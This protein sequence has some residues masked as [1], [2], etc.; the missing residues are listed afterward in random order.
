MSEDD[1]E[2]VARAIWASVGPR[3]ENEWGKVADHTKEQWRGMARAAIA[4]IN[5][6]K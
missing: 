3:S 4:A 5:P 2:R 1:V 6:P